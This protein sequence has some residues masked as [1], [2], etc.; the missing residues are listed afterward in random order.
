MPLLEPVMQT[1]E[2]FRDVILKQMSWID[3]FA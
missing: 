3:Y 2:F 1:I